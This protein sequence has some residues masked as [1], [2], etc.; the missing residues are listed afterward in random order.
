MNSR[1][2]KERTMMQL[3]FRFIGH[4]FIDVGVATL[5]A[6]A[7]VDDPARLTEEAVQ[8]FAD[9]MLR[10]Y[11]APSM[12]AFLGFTV[13]G[14]AKFA[15]PNQLKPEFDDKRREILRE[16]LML[17][18][19]GARSQREQP[20]SPGEVCAFSGDPAVVR[21]S[22]V[23]IPLITD[24]KN[25]NFVP[26]GVP[27][28]PI[29]GWCLLAMLAMPLGGL[30]SKGKMWVVHSFDPQA[31]LY[32]AGR[33]L[34]RNRRDFQMQGLNKRPNYKFA[35]THLLRDVTEAGAYALNRSSYG[36]TAYLFTSSA[37]KSEVE[38]DHLTSPVLRFIR[39][40]QRNVPDAWGRVVRRAERLN[41]GEENEDGVRTYTQ[42]NYFYEDLFTLPDNAYGFLR[43]Y[44]LRDPIPGKPR[45]EAK[46]DPR[47]TYSLI[48][49][50][51]LVN[52]T[53]VELFLMEVMDM[54]K[55]RIEAIRAI[56]DRAA[57][58]IQHVD[59]R[60]FRNLFNARREQ[61]FRLILLRADK[62]AS[63]PLFGLDEYVLAFF[64]TTEQET[65]RTDWQLARDL[66]LIRIIETLHRNNQTE[67]VQSAVIEEDTAEAV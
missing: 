39:R 25:I 43:R 10:L 17:W 21:V 8:A 36:L 48:G 11:I 29:S 51:D 3:P 13:F 42:R 35:R 6:A 16:A 2:E 66:L 34:A 19:P 54:D 20:A 53:L 4:P 33:N 59:S 62:E 22:R 15:N 63:P 12:S 14:N 23:Y 46:D 27:R 45:G 26:E 5:C 38:I 44:L 24:E 67:L 31:I 18:R 65:L 50:I 41:T 47:Y 61:D 49:E 9:E 1:E 52:W 37:Q 32:F 28:L 60:L 30:A 40:A 57:D 64:A 58:Y 55:E 56:A 7:G